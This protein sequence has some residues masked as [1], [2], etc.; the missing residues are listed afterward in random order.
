MKS[1]IENF[2]ASKYADLS[3]RLPTLTAQRAIA[4][5]LDTETARIDALIA[6]KRQM[7]TLIADRLLAQARV[8]VTGKGGGPSWEPGPHWLGPVPTE[9][10]PQ[11]IAWRKV[12]ASGTT[13]PAGDARYYAE[14]DGFPWVTTSELRETVITSASRAV[15]KAALEEFSALKI[16]PVGSVLVAMYG[17]TVG[18]LGVL[19][20]RAASNQACCAI[21]GGRDLDQ[22]FLYWWLRAHRDDLVDMAYGSGQP[23]ISQELVRGLRVPAPPIA[24]Q[25][26]IARG[27]DAAEDEAARIIRALEDQTDLLVEHRQALITA[28]VT[29]EL[30]I[31]G[32]AA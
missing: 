24:I 25:Q 6:K 7:A 29:G 1:T 21:Y 10:E 3:L 19:G 15:T 32:V 2:S 28:A 5:Y 17:A 8:T 20:I 14:S 16:Y 23:N 22:G 4:D 30:E 13:P 9:W 18:R 26:E 27:L 11:K 31:P 12:T